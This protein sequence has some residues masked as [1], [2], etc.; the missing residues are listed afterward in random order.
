MTV[1]GPLVYYRLAYAKTDPRNRHGAWHLQRGTTTTFFCGES[2]EPGRLYQR[3]ELPKM[4]LRPSGT[5]CIKCLKTA[6]LPAS[7]IDIEK[8]KRRRRG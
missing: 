6:E 8:T 7:T 2:Q 1:R 4:D 5:T 3:W